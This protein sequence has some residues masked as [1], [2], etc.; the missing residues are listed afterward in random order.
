MTII[1]AP[2]IKYKQYTP[3]IPAQ[4]AVRS[5]T[6][7]LRQKKTPGFKIINK[8]N[9]NSI[10]KVIDLAKKTANRDETCC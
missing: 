5:I 1:S 7:W 3:N 2:I 8:I 4:N 9:K 10:S 6:D